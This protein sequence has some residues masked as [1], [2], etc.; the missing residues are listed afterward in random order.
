MEA[1]AKSGFVHADPLALDALRPCGLEGC[2]QFG[3]ERKS[4]YD[5]V[6]GPREETLR[7]T[8]VQ[9]AVAEGPP[10]EFAAFEGKVTLDRGSPM[11]QRYISIVRWPRLELGLTKIVVQ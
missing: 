2:L 8:S 11:A 6:G 10:H 4:R 1:V 7:K 3:H 5:S 9:V